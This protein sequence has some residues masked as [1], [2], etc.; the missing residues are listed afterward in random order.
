MPAFFIRHF[1][2]ST[3]SFYWRTGQ[4]SAS[5]NFALGTVCVV[6]GDG[7]GWVCGCVGVV[8]LSTICNGAEI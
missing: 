6:C 5:S 8:L 4:F 1:N 3:N 2:L 7:G